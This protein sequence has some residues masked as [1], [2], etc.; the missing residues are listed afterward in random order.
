MI[1]GNDGINRNTFHRCKQPI[2]INKTDIK[3]IYISDKD[4]HENKGSFKYFIEYKSNE[5]IRPFCIKL[6]QLSGY[7]KYFDENNKCMNFL[8]HTKK[9]LKHT[10]QHGPKLVN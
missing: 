7:A 4:L 5:C 2:N 6:L 1:F 10:I 8:F 3:K 9:L